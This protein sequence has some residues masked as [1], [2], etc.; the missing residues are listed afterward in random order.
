M[1]DISYLMHRRTLQPGGL[2]KGVSSRQK[3]ILLLVMFCSTAVSGELT[4]EQCES[5]CATMPSTINVTS[6]HYGCS[7]RDGT[8]G[9]VGMCAPESPETSEE[10]CEVGRAF[11]L[12][13]E[14]SFSPGY[15]RCTDGYLYAVD[16]T[17][18]VQQC[19][20]CCA[21][22][23]AKHDDIDSAYCDIGCQ[24]SGANLC[25]SGLPFPAII[26]C[27]LG[28]SLINEGFASIGSNSQEICI[29]GHIIGDRPCSDYS[30]KNSCI[31]D[32]NCFFNGRAKCKEITTCKNM[33]GMKSRCEGSDLGCNWKESRKRCQKARRN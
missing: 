9:D 21:E 22:L 27:G 4:P 5:C 13:D 18:N 17:V 10:S 32:N 26:S 8:T 1:S 23:D 29:D 14:A 6:C 16:K 12:G 20:N 15:F 24:S 30:T 3:M 11:L 19:K 28:R 33:N 7:L 2:G 25:P 31:A